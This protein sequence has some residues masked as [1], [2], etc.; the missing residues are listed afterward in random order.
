MISCTITSYQQTTVYNNVKSVTLPTPS[1]E[2]QVLSGHAESFI[3]LRQGDILLK[4]ATGKQNKTV[5]VVQ[6][7]CYIKKDSILIVL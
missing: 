6:G 7:E 3:L 5:H 2:M 4:Q 1:G